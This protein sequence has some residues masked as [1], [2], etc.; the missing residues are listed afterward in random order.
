MYLPQ[1]NSAYKELNLL[2][3]RM[4][5]YKRTMSMSMDADALASD[6]SSRINHMNYEHSSLNNLQYLYVKKWYKMQVYINISE[7]MQAC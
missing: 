2:G 1:Q 3:L 5:Y 6:I 7:R 4:E